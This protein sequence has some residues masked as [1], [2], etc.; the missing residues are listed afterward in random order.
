M[1]L[2]ANHGNADLRTWDKTW[3]DLPKIGPLFPRLH[4]VELVFV[5]VLLLHLPFVVADVMWGGK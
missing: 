1:A 3:F 2:R 4:V 5:D